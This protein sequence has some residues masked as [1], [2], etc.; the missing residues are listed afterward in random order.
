MPTLGRRV[1]GPEYAMPVFDT[2][3]KRGPKVHSQDVIPVGTLS[4]YMALT[5]FVTSLQVP[6]F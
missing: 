3:P 6:P 2:T 1:M 4:D 5:S